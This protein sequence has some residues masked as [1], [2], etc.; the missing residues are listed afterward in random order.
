MV[1][2]Q[3]LLKHSLTL[4]PLNLKHSHP[5]GTDIKIHLSDHMNM[6]HIIT[7]ILLFVQS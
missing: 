7:Q 5:T 4:V 6:R 1:Y 3:I 2:G